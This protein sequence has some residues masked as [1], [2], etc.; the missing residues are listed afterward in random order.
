M[1]T[2]KF[3]FGVAVVNN[4][5]HVLTIGGCNT[6][7]L[8]LVESYDVATNSW[9]TLAPMPTA[10]QGAAVAV[11]GGRVWTMGGYDGRDLDVIE[12][13]DIDRDTWE[14]SGI[15]M[16]CPRYGAHAVVVDGRI[17]V[18]GGFESRTGSVGL[19]EIFDPA[20]GKWESAP[21]MKT[22]RN[23]HGVVGF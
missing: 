8:A 6:S 18:A 3:G 1:Q 17:V 12:V 16:T 7:D 10:R 9:A 5:Q 14:T 22:P 2:E 21:P 15:K 11:V 13:Y 20:T 23:S 4:A 19:V